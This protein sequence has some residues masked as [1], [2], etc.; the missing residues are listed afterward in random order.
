MNKKQK[1]N[2]MKKMFLLL[3]AI[4]TLA[5]TLTPQQTNAS[6]LVAGDITYV[7][8]SPGV[9]LVTITLYRDCAGINLGT[10]ALLNFTSSC[11]SG[12]VSL[13]QLGTATQI[14]ASPCLP[15]S[16]TTCNGGTAYGV[17]EW[18]YQGL[19]TLPGNCNDWTFSYSTC[20]RKA[21]ISNIAKC[22]KSIVL[23]T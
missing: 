3:I 10:T 6:H 18:V 5:I 13:S 17:E 9:F 4:F 12:S 11:G 16:T 1:P 21:Q 14:P 15:P 8:V 23:Y 19:V 2:N 20:C 7:Y 22:R